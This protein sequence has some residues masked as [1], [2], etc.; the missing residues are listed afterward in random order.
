MKLVK[1]L[2][3]VNEIGNTE[4]AFIMR[5]YEGMRS[6]KAFQGLVGSD[7]N[8]VANEWMAMSVRS[9]IEMMYAV[10]FSLLS[11]HFWI[12]ESTQKEISSSQNHRHSF[13]PDFLDDFRSH[14]PLIREQFR[15]LQQEIEKDIWKKE[16]Q[17]AINKLSERVEEQLNSISRPSLPPADQRA[18]LAR[19]HAT[20]HKME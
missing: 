6:G 13:H 8:K 12:K 3:N 1:V 16:A 19:S 9:E 14:L 11:L 17:G 18:S 4:Y 10:A 20:A 5:V 2:G 15:S 7:I